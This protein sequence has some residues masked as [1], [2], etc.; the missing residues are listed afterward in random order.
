V[1]CRPVK[2]L[3]VACEPVACKPVQCKPGRPAFCRP[4]PCK[5]VECIPCSPLPCDPVPCRPVHCSQPPGIEGHGMAA[6]P[7]TVPVALAVGAA[8]SVLVMGVV[9][10]L[11][12]VIR[13]MPI[14]VSGI[15]FVGSI[16]LTFYLSSRY[17][18][19]AREL[20]QRVLGAVREAATS[21]VDRATSA[22]TRHL[23][24]VR[25]CK[26]TIKPRP[27]INI[28]EWLRS[29]SV[30]LHPPLRYHLLSGGG[31]GKRKE[32]CKSWNFLFFC[33]VCVCMEGRAE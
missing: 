22:L 20:G 13:Y 26:V 14:Y 25:F 11:G 5:P 4:V 12:F 8:A 3:P 28:S 29:R 7:M 16:A 27:S 19:S 17:P 6:S 2:C 18:A 32:S 33:F 24:Q 23:P 30:G 9:A 1:D 10:F 31:G 21:V 15:V